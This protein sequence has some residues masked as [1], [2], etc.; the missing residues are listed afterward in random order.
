M[1]WASEHIARLLRG[2]TVSF[3]PVG[4]SMRP[5]IESGQLVTVEPLGVSLQHHELKPGDIVL[6]RIVT[7]EYVHLVKEVRYV[8]GKWRF[9]IGNNH[10]KV[11]GWATQSNV[12]GRVVKIEP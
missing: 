6:C 9:L 10:G 1:G 2:E 4:G 11:N 7:W 5:L 12:F 8:E 3:R